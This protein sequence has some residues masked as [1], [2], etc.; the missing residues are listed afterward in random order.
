M[1]MLG[2]EP[3]ISGVRS[4]HSTKC[5]TTTAQFVVYSLSFPHQFQVFKIKSCL[6]P[7]V[8]PSV[9]I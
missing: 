1:L 6:R 7:N 9:F 4:D 5:A 3:W 8:F 2:F